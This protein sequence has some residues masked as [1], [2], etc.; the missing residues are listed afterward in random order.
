[1]GLENF[2]YE[3]AIYAVKAY[4]AKGLGLTKKDSMEDV[5]CK[6]GLVKLQ[7]QAIKGRRNFL[8]CDDVHKAMEELYIPMPVDK[9]RNLDRQFIV[10]I[11]VSGC[12]KTRTCYDLSRK[13]YV[14]YFDCAED[15]D[16]HNLFDRLQDRVPKEKTEKLQEDFEKYTK[17]LIRCLIASRLLVLHQNYSNYQTTPFDWMCMQRSHTTRNIFSNLFNQLCNLNHLVSSRIF[18]EAQQWFNGCKG[19]LI[20]D[21]A[22]ALLFKCKDAFL[23]NNNREIVNGKISQPRSLYSF[24]SSFQIHTI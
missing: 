15:F 23:A 8:I 20:F 7:V 17:Y 1:M 14:L 9:L 13:E 4:L 5:C 16:I 6:N 11:G 18:N 12:G 10:M 19:R 21:E 22:Q 3:T 2:S 24:L